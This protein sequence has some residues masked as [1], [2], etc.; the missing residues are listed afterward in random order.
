[1][2]V[3][4]WAKLY[5]SMSVTMVGMV[6]DYGVTFTSMCSCQPQ[7]KVVRFTSKCFGSVT[8]F[9]CLNAWSL[10][11]MFGIVIMLKVRV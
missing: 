11:N 6:Y 2:F 5:S 7:G 9:V 8:V 1:M 10:L 3:L 4:V